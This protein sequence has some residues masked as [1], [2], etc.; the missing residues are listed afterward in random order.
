MTTITG[1]IAP[2]LQ[3]VL[4]VF[5][6]S[7]WSMKMQRGNEWIMLFKWEW[8]DLLLLVTKENANLQRVHMAF[9]TLT[10]YFRKLCKFFRCYFQA[11]I[12]WNNH[13]KVFLEKSYSKNLI[14]KKEKNCKLIMR[15]NIQKLLRSRL[16]DYLLFHIKGNHKYI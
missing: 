9:S 6:R 16:L 3:H 2:R 1:K 14:R 10:N 7:K 12:S 15:K 4:F 11:C 5:S 13:R 8:C